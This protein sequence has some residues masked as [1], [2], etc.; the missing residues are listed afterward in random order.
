VVSRIVIYP[1]SGPLRTE[2]TATGR[3][4]FS[5]LGIEQRT[6]TLSHVEHLTLPAI[7]LHRRS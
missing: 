6:L 3:W 5:T 7:E 4:T 2:L 1:R